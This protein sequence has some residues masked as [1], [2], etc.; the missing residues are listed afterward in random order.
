MRAPSQGRKI[1]NIDQPALPQPLSVWS[2]N[3]SSKQ[4]NHTISAAIQIKNQ[5]L[6]SMIS[7]KFVVPIATPLLVFA[8]AWLA[9]TR[10]NPSGSAQHL[11]RSCSR[12]LMPECPDR[13]HDASPGKDDVSPQAAAGTSNRD[14]RRGPPRRAREAA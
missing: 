6:H 14:A 3:M 7:Q 9:T 11:T 10:E 13:W 5:K 1:S 8:G 4:R 2:P 12:P